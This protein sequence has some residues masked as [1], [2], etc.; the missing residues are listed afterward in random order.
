[1]ALSTE[2]NILFL[3]SGGWKNVECHVFSVYSVV[4]NT[5]CMHFTASVFHKMK[6]NA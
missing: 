2:V 6:W 5:V 3:A 4:V 1:M